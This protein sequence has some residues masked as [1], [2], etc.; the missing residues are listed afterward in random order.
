MVFYS[1]GRINPSRSWDRL[2][3]DVLTGVWRRRK[4]NKIFTVFVLF[5]ESGALYVAMLVSGILIALSHAK[6]METTDLLVTSFV[7]GGNESVGRMI[8]CTSGY[9]TV[10]LV[11]S[12]SIEKLAGNLDTHLSQGIYPTLMLVILRESVWNA[13]EDCEFSMAI[14]TIHSPNQ[15]SQTPSDAV[16]RSVNLEN[17][18]ATSLIVNL[19]TSSIASNRGAEGRTK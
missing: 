9:S 7:V 5:V 17:G 19:W 12:I 3:R 6:G 4:A 15:P 2:M 1:R 8:D 11:V 13:P 10:Q 18:P 14:S 16:A